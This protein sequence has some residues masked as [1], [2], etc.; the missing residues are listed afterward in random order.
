VFGGCENGSII[1]WDLKNL[2]HEVMQ[3]DST[4][5][6]KLLH[7]KGKLV[8]GFKSNQIKLYDTTKQFQQDIPIEIKKK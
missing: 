6:I 5:I 8:A 7:F 3:A 4:Q 2:S 1:A